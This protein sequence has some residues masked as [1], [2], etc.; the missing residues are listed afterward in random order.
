MHI[1]HTVHTQTHTRSHTHTL[2]HS[3]G[4]NDNNKTFKKNNLTSGSNS[5]KKHMSG[6]F[7]GVLLAALYVYAH[8]SETLKSF[9]GP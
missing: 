6:G 8:V 2:T 9:E 5:L 7:G 3:Q 1:K 4:N